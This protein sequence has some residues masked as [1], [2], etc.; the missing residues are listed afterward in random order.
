MYLQN[1]S[2]DTRFEALIVRVPWPEW[3]AELE[4][5]RY[6]NAK[7]VPVTFVD[8]H[9]GLR[10][11]VR[12]PVPR[13]GRGRRPAGQQLR[14][15]SSA[16][17]RPRAS[18]A[19]SA[20]AAELLR[21]NL[22]P[23]AAALLRSRAAVA[24]RLPALGPRPRPH[25]QPRRPAV[26]P[27]HDP[28]AHRRTGCTR[29]RSC[30][31]TSPR[32]ARR[33]SSRR[34]GFAFA[35]HVQYAILFDRLF[36]FP[37]TGSR[38]RNYDGLGGQLLFAYLHKHGFVHWT[39]NRLTIE[40][41]RVADG[42]QAL[43]AT[44][45]ELYRAGIDRSKVAHWIAAHD[46][47]A[48]YVPPATV[49]E[50][51]A[52]AARPL[53]RRERPEG[54]D[55]PRRARRVPA[56]DV[57][58]RSCRASSSRRQAV[59]GVSRRRRARAAALGPVRRAA[60]RRGRA[61]RSRSSTPTRRGSRAC[62]ATHHVGRPARRRRRARDVGRRRS[63]ASTGVVHLVGGWRGGKP[64]PR[65]AAR[66]LGAAARPARPHGPAHDARVRARAEGGGRAGR[67][68]LVSSQQ[69]AGADE[70]ERRLRARRRRRPRRG[71]SRSPTS[72]PRRRRLRT[73]SS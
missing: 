39:D 41:D 33:S 34:E 38:V 52:R 5:T 7:F 58:P 21:L 6:D 54:V 66:G 24:R 10:Q 43:R 14:R 40:W 2:R 51:G 71:R 35:R 9:R 1:A 42:V 60:A 49:V 37:I 63:T 20:A 12:G 57:L 48:T 65:G 18:A 28:P 62:R 53:E 4:R 36:R 8:T 61:R 69:A 68:V 67:F 47:V 72:S 64:L 17:A 44:V 55:R 29:S 15:R 25:A 45:E 23:D 30:A 50:V 32:S 11:R 26:R 13:D 27:V 19:S 70:H 3:L 46:L 22:P 73:S 16:T 59:A 31:A 56:V